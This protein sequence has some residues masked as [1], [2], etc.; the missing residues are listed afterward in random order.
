MNRSAELARE[1]RIPLAIAQMDI[2]K[3]FD[4]ILHEACFEAMKRKNFSPFTVAPMAAIWSA[5]TVIVTLG[6]CSSDI[7]GMNRGLPQG[8][9]ES[10]MI[11]TLLI[12]MV[13]ENVSQNGVA[14][15]GAL[16]WTPST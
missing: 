14:T 3:A 2:H 15:G 5:T 11:F 1:R 9:P 4:H 6:H 16:L 10:P 13:I 12:D 8:A 7:I